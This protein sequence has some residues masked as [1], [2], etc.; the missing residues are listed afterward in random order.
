MNSSWFKKMRF[1]VVAAVA[2]GVG[3]ASAAT[4]VSSASSAEFRFDTREGARESTGTETLAYSAL[5][6]G[7]SNSVVT[8]S[9]ACAT[10]HVENGPVADGLVLEGEWSWTAQYDGTYTLTHATITDGVTGKVETATFVVSGLG[11]PMADLTA[12]IAWKLLK[13]TGTY[14]AQ[15]KDQNDR[16]LQNR[17]SLQSVRGKRCRVSPRRTCRAPH[18]GLQTAQA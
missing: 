12:E 10:L 18:N 6:S 2:L 14:F 15:L 17:L 8:I 3:I 9:Q 4:V 7:D 11:P 13:A 16:P 1:A 5:W